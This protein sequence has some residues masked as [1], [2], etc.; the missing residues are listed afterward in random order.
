MYE[1]C[2]LKMTLSCIS[3]I[4]S[5]NQTWLHRCRRM[6]SG[7]RHLGEFPNDSAQILKHGTSWSVIHLWYHHNCKVR[8]LRV[9]ITELQLNSTVVRWF[10]FI[11]IK[12]SWFSVGYPLLNMQ[13]Y[14]LQ[15][16]CG[17]TEF[18]RGHVQTSRKHK[19]H[20]SRKIHY[21]EFFST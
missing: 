5:T 19:I 1:K 3:T 10:Y 13:K 20:L 6:K 8:C 2:C 4:C 11:F 21:V 18:I 9:L 12:F 16:K 17:F 15:A 7:D 14:L